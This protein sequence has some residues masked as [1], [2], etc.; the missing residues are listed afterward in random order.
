MRAENPSAQAAA[1]TLLPLTLLL[2]LIAWTYLARPDEPPTP[3]TPRAT[4]TPTP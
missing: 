4:V 1:L 2:A 3:T